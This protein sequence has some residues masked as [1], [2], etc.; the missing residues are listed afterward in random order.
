G[1]F[2][3]DLV[4]QVPG[5]PEA[6][7][8][9][10]AARIGGGATTLG[11]MYSAGAA[12]AFLVNLFSGRAKHVRRQGVVILVA[13]AAWGAAIVGFGL[14]DTLWVALILLAAANGADM[15]SGIFR[16]TIPNAITPDPLRGRVAGSVWWWLRQVP[17]SAI[18]R[19]AWSRRS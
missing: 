7:F 1:T 19:P 9:A 12:G 14:A 17:L 16:M 13:T 5:V 3:A 10:V 6:L 15:L 18:S 8:P 11:L 2:L 4:G